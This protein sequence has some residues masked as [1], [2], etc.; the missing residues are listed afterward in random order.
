MRSRPFPF[1]LPFPLPILACAALTLAP[2]AAQASPVID[3][4]GSIGGNGGVQGVVSGPGPSS[5]FFNPAL[6]ID[7]EDSALVAFVL[8][9]EQI[10][11]TLDGRRGG[12]VPLE[13]GGR[14]ILG[15][16][17]KPV[18]NG[19]VPTQWLQLGCPPGTQPGNCPP[20]GFAAR[21][22]QAAGTS[23][24]TRTYLTL[25]M[26]KDLVKDRL[27]IGLYGMIPL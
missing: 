16:D 17:L 12:D 13:V 7:A 22:R 21:P 27:T 11:V 8:V 3:L 23:G 18:P 9:S 6:L 24:K 4:T 10:G 20:P 19:V 5:A 14:D 26:A 25:G 15:P 1:P 2:R